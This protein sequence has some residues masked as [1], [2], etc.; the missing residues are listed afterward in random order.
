MTDDAPLRSREVVRLVAGRE[1]AE[2]L[3]AKSFYIGTG[4]LLVVILAVG[5]ISRVAGDDGPDVIKVG[6]VGAASDQVTAV[7][8]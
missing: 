5:V 7:I 1:I 4:L 2:R 3:R 8:D 6:F